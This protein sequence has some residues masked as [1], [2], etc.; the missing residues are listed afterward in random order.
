MI[1]ILD[2]RTIIETTKLPGSE[3]SSNS[4]TDALDIIHWTYTR[5]LLAQR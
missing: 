2:E 5:S 3:T 1:S 4:R